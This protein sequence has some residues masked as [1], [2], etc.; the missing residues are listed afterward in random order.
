MTFCLRF[1][2]HDL[3]RP[4]GSKRHVGNG[5]MVE[6][7]GQPLRNW[8]EAV[9]QA[10]LDNVEQDHHPFDGPVF[11]S[12]L[13]YLPRP[14]CHYRTGKNAHLLR[15]AAPPYPHHKPDLDKL[16]RSCCDSLT[17]AGV[18]TDDSRVVTIAA[19]KVY[20]DERRPTPGAMVVVMEAS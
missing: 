1:S 18:W 13:F 12:V 15:D 10:A 16:A 6:S 14:K 20:C 19:S 2:V 9:K 3:P 4:Q 11:L 8:R 17:A 5:I 7:G